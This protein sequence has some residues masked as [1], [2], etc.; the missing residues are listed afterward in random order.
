M[1]PTRDIPS[2]SSLFSAYASMAA[3]M[4]LVRSMANEIIPQPVRG[5]L[6]STLRYYFKPHSDRLTLIIEENCGMSRNQVYDAAEVYLCTKISPN[7]ERLKISKS[8]KEKNLMIRL[9]KGEK[10]ID[11]YDGVEL[12][13]RFVCAESEKSNPN[14]SQPR[15]EKRFFELTFLKKHK[16][17]ILNTYVPFFLERA[18]AIKDEERDLKMYTLNS[19]YAYH[20]VKWESI[21]LEHPATFETLAMDPELKN[22]VIEDLDRFVKRKEFYKRVGRAWKRGYLLYGPPGTGKSSLIAAMA[23]HLRFDVYDLQLAN[24][25]R[26]S[27]LR[28]LLLATA[29]RS[30]LVIEDIDCSVELQDRRR[31][32]GRKQSDVQLVQ[33]TLSG[34]LNFIDGLWSSC[35]DERIIVFTTNHKER[36]DPALLRP[37][38]MDMHIHMSYCTSH[39]FKQLANTYLGIR[40]HHSL[41]SE[42]EGYLENTHVTPAQVA[43]ELMKSD[44]ADVALQGLIKLLKRKNI[45]GDDAAADAAADQKNAG[46][47]KAKRQKLENKPRKSTRNTR[48]KSVIRR[49]KCL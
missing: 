16:E 26:D 7:T 32:D 10:L 40:G 25:L 45:E 15:S 48:A 6:L 35:G 9:E 11:L 21:N 36:L 1:F 30:I 5:F 19:S 31:V 34:L 33:L 20:G 4:M 43:E 23:N 28:K 12:K 18:K 41:F 39:G 24:I 8:P 22:S 3:S 27:D 2:P 37:G 49:R 38:R 29:N 46:I 44:N 13:W 42:I 47:Q 14:D 17:Q